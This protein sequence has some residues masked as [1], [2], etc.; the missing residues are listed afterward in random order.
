MSA[1]LPKVD[2]RKRHRYVRS[3]RTVRFTLDGDGSRARAFSNVRTLRDVR[4]SVLCWDYGQRTCRARPAA[5][6]V[7]LQYGR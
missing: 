6:R 3:S 1:L 4:L 2:I 5:R 7:F